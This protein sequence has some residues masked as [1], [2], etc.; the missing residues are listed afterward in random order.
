MPIPGPLIRPTEVT[1]DNPMLACLLSSCPLPL[2]EH[3]NI[4]VLYDDVSATEGAGGGGGGPKL[5]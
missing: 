1:H 4:L 5:F 3:Y 2:Q